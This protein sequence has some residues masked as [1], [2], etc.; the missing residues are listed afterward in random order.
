MAKYWE[1]FV[2]GETYEGESRTVTEADVV[3]FADISEDRNPLHLDEE[4]A[5]KTLYGKRIAHGMLVLSK[6]TGLHYGLGIF[7]GTSLGVVEIQWKFKKPVFLG[8]TIQFEACVE[9]K[10]ETSKMDRGILVRKIT[11][12]N[13]QGDIVQEGKFINLIKR[14]NPQIQ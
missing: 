10:I 4:F 12:R 5:S 14:N 3:R 13:G 7:K 11:V 2:I 6:V 9:D 1:D 8:D